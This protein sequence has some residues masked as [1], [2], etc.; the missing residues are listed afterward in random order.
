MQ[1]TVRNGAG[2]G[3]LLLLA[4]VGVFGDGSA[5]AGP[6]GGSAGEPAQGAQ[7]ERRQA[8]YDAQQRPP[9]DPAV[10][11]RAVRRSTASIAAAAT[12]S[13]FEEETSEV[14]TCSARSSSCATARES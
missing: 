5:A 8:P 7:R 11:A 3:A 9:G 13:T 10:I 1:R 6:A 12:A 4:T 2:L 14:R